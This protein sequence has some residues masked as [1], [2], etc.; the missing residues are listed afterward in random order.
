M[1]RI[2]LRLFF[3]FQHN[4]TKHSKIRTCSFTE[5]DRLFILFMVILAYSIDYLINVVERRLK[6]LT[7]MIN[8]IKYYLEETDMLKI[9][10]NHLSVAGIKF[11]LPQ[12]FYIDIEGMEVIHQDGLR[13]ISPEKNCRISFMTTEVEFDTP[14]NSLMD[15]F[16]DEA[17]DIG[18]A[19][20]MW[21]PNKTGYIWVEE[22][23][24]SEINGLK[25]AYVK[26]HTKYYYY[27]EIHFER[28][29]GAD[30]QLEVLLEIPKN[31]SDIE[32]VLGRQN[33]KDF[34]NSFELV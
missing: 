1:S 2:T 34:Y 7:Q 4:S 18:I 28:V 26:Y 24:A 8:A 3:V 10:G 17:L 20:D 25:C 14:V 23:Q 32:A 12:N 27:Y 11:M 19:N 21:S 13:L 22:P 5:F 33:V 30:R 16:V 29:E 6:Y 15:I 31:L 9:E